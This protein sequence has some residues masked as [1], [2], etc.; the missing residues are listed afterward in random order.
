MLFIYMGKIVGRV[1]LER[2]GV[3]FWICGDVYW[4]VGYLKLEVRESFELKI[5]IWE[6]LI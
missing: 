6:L 4:V 1:N 3:W 5:L 2:L